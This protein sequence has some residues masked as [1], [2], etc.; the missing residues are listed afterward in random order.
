MDLV[1]RPSL[2]NEFL[3][4]RPDVLRPYLRPV[5]LFVP[6]KVVPVTIRRKLGISA[7]SVLV[8]GLTPKI[9]VHT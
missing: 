5:R 4:S 2:T 6:R 7:Y 8:L 9:R 3:L 1:Y